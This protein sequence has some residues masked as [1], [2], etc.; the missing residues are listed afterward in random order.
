M[1]ELD[2]I[3]NSYDFI[4]I[5][6]NDTHEIKKNV[7]PQNIY[8]DGFIFIDNDIPDNSTLSYVDNVVSICKN[9]EHL[10]KK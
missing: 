6:Q 4:I 3:K 1:I 2:E 9:K 8:C 7:S 10:K 5:S